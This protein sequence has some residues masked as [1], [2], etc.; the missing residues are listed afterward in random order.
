[1]VHRRH[2]RG[3]GRTASDPT[4]DAKR[5][6]IVR[7]IGAAARKR[8]RA[9]RRESAP[10]PSPDNVTRLCWADTFGRAISPN[11]RRA[12]GPATVVAMRP[13]VNRTECGP[14]VRTR[15]ALTTKITTSLP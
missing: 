13:R 14:I 4:F 15:R 1:M 3:V 12:E 7:W 11:P 9:A 6:L 5:P 8:S 10:A 2:R